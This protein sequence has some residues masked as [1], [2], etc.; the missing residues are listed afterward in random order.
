MDPSAN[1]H[2]RRSRPD[3]DLNIVGDFLRYFVMLFVPFFLIGATYGFINQCYLICFLVNPVIYAGGVC[4]IIIVIKYD[5]NDIMALFGRA[6]EQQL[7][8][9]VKHAGTI[10]QIGVQ[11]SGGDY[12]GALVTVRKL[13]REEPDYPNAL[14]LKGQILLDGFAQYEEARACFDKVMTLTGPESEDYLLAEALKASTYPD[15]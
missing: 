7:A 4:L 11:M 8:L 14:N 12:E 2:K 15:E 5:V 10:Q 1:V 3:R 9:H 13:L 6:R